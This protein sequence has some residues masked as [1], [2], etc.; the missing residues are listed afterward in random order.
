MVMMGGKGG[1]EE[2]KGWGVRMVKKQFA[3]QG[4]WDTCNHKL[5]K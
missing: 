3:D 4:S 2:E 5:A 1:G